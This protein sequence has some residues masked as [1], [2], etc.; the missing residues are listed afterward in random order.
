MYK[1]W[2]N[3]HHKPSAS[4]LNAHSRHWGGFG[5]AAGAMVVTGS[6]SLVDHQC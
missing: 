6:E 1:S 2:S 5:M 3:K 4:Y